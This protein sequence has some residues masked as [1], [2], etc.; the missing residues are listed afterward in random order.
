MSGFRETALGGNL[1]NLR[2][3]IGEEVLGPLDSGLNQVVPGGNMEK[4]M[5]VPVKL[6][7]L[8]AGHL[9]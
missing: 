2:G 9:A 6:A 7:F 3:L 1:L 8:H 5:V 4:L